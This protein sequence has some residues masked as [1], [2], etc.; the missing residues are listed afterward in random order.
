MAV[1]TNDLITHF[2]DPIFDFEDL[3]DLEE[4]SNN[5]SLILRNIIQSGQWIRRSMT[6]NGNQRGN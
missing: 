4:F 6:N 5:D 3:E 2:K 1:R